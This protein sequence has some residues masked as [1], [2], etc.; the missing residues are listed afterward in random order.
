[1]G[2]GKVGERGLLFCQLALVVRVIPVIIEMR[3]QA[4]V[5]MI[6]TRHHD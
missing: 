3:G 5:G 2:I 6:F 4:D 1:M